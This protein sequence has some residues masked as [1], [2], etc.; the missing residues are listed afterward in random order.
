MPQVR[1]NTSVIVT[2]QDI[3]IPIFSQLWLTRNALLREDEVGPESIFTPGVV[4]VGG[5]RFELTVLPDRLQ[6]RFENFA[7]AQAD[8]DRVLGGIVKILPH[9]PYTAVGMNF[10]WLIAPGSPPDFVG[11]NAKRF[12]APCAPDAEEHRFGSYFSF[13]VNGMRARVDCRP[14]RI[15]SEIPVVLEQFKA[16]QEVMAINVNFQ[17]DV[18]AE[19][20]IERMLEKLS[21]WNDLSA[22]SDRIATGLLE[23]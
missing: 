6:L 8:I 9:T 13:P 23:Q 5:P 7:N 3:N 17:Y 19:T 22:I 12:R 2:A 18:P 14:V 21:N 16:D 20:G 4:R 10:D 15:K 1:A 11:W